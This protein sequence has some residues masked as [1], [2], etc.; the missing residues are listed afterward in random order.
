MEAKIFDP[1]SEQA[2]N[3]WLEAGPE[4]VVLSAQVFDTKVGG[5]ERQVA[6]VFFVE[7]RPVTSGPASAATPAPPEHKRAVTFGSAADL[8]ATTDPSRRGLHLG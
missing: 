5:V 1:I 4:K 7:E 6:L 2:I 3:A 8:P